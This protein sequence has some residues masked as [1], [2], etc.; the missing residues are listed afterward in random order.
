M[1]TNVRIQLT[2]NGATEEEIMKSINKLCVNDIKKS[3]MSEFNQDKVNDF[4]D[5]YCFDIELV[6]I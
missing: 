5:V 3:L 1:N 4:D 2:A 6:S